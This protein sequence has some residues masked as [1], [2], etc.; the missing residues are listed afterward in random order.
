MSAPAPGSSF[1]IAGLRPV[2]EWPFHGHC[3]QSAG[4][5]LWGRPRRGSGEPE[6]HCIPPK[7][8]VS[9]EGK[10]TKKRNETKKKPNPGFDRGRAESGFCAGGPTKKPSVDPRH[11][12]R[13]SKYPR[14]L[15]SWNL[16]SPPKMQGCSSL[17][18]RLGWPLNSPSDSLR[19]QH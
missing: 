1:A 18:H 17:E 14:A 15:F 2:F 4:A 19:T 8:K 7:I 3:S 11:N 13:A 5:P 16:L 9:P 10:R 12:R 6:K